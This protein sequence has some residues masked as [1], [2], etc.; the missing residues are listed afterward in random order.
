MENFDRFSQ[1]LR[2]HTGGIGGVQVGHVVVARLE[3]ASVRVPP[4]VTGGPGQ[5]WEEGV[6]EV[7]EGP[8]DDDVVVDAHEA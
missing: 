8:R 4:V 1:I 2:S 5:R 3:G 7:V 6:E